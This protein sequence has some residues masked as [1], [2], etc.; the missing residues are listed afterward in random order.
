MPAK[1]RSTT[2]RRQSVDRRAATPWVPILLVAALALLA[3]SLYP[4]MRL[5]YQT[6]RRVAGLEEQYS[7]L[8]QRNRSLRSEVADLKTPEG[9]E[10][11]ARESLGFAKEGE[12]VYV[13][14]PTD[15]ATGTADVAAQAPGRSALQVVLDALFGVAPP[16]DP[17]NEP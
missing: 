15:G 1:Q 10:R 12:N 4:A 13:V 2:A 14:M 5:Q 3:W 9:V 16:A 8:R 11:A 17:A 6:G 7:Q